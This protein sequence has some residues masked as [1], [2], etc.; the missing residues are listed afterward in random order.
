MPRKTSSCRVEVQKTCM[1]VLLVDG[2][3][4][5]RIRDRLELEAEEL[6]DADEIL[7]DLEGEESEHGD[8][9]C[10]RYHNSVDLNNIPAGRV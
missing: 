7:S 9:P 3:V 1:Y 2:Q 8:L 5:R 10:R 4:Q 6:A